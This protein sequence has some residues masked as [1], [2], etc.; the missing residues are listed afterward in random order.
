MER[1]WFFVLLAW[2]DSVRRAS[3]WKANTLKNK[4]VVSSSERGAYERKTRGRCEQ[5]PSI[6]SGWLH[7]G[8]LDSFFFFQFRNFPGS[9]PE[10]PR[11][12]D[13]LHLFGIAASHDCSRHH[14]VPQGPR[15]R[16]FPWRPP[17]GCA[18][19]P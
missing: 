6:V 17:V 13:P 18:D 8:R 14:G 5:I 4:T 12:D 9:E 7:T 3:D 19:F 11:P 16:N 15:D 1:G 10:I 2:A